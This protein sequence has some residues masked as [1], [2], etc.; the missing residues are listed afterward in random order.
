[1]LSEMKR[2]RPNKPIGMAGKPEEK[3]DLKEDSF[4][5]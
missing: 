5:R 4:F 2:A 1:M 3:K